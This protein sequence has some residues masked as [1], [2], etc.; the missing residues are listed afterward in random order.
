[1]QPAWYTLRVAVKK[2]H[3]CAAA[4]DQLDG[5]AAFCPR[6]SQRKKARS[7][8][9]WFTEAMFPGYLFAHFDFTDRH[10]QVRHARDVRTILHFGDQYPTIPQPA[11]D[12]I[13]S[14]LNA[15][16]IAVIPD[17]LDPETKVVVTSGPFMG[18]EAIVTRVMPA[19]DR[20]R[21]LIEL[22]GRS[23]ET[24]LPSSHVVTDH[25]EK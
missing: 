18:F 5:I 21:I 15:D 9:R 13:R 6:I 12:Q 14:Q 10:R 11:I 2:E 3:Q 24:E 23:L 4:L 19:A 20:V 7:G 22:L 25:Q 8:A 17:R 16:G 1:M